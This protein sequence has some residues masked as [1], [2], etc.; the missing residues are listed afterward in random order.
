MREDN[1]PRDRERG[2]GRRDDFRDDRREDRVDD[3]TDRGYDD[4]SE[5]REDRVDDRQDYYDD[6]R[7]DYADRRFVRGSRYS[8]AW[9]G[10]NS[11]SVTD[12]VE[13]DGEKYYQCENE[14]FGRT[15]YGGEV[16]Y[17]VIDP[18]PGY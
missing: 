9:W 13:V 4:R 2:E 6:R 14:W 1:R 10:S 18:P 7:D 8:S 5:R 3:R 17:T 11:C 15:Y 12:V 16:T